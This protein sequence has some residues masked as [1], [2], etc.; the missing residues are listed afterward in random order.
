M[1]TSIEPWARRFERQHPKRPTHHL[2]VG[3]NFPD[4]RHGRVEERD[5]LGVA[6]ETLV[7]SCLG[8]QHP[9]WLSEYAVAAVNAIARSGRPLALLNLGA[10]APGLSGLDSAVAVHKPGYLRAERFAT[11]LAASDL[12]L[13]PLVDGVSTRRGSLMAALQHGL[14]VVGT[15]G[16]LTDS[17]LREAGPAL[18]LTEV[19]DVDSFSR[20]AAQLAN[21]PAAR[22]RAGAAA[23]ALYEREFEWSVI[24]DKLLAALP[25]S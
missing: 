10:E 7:I 11:M 17:V 21:D 23:R 15:V 25:D 4:A 3:S 5:R 20:S 14:P 6:E 13:T 9:G 1:L 2:P 24:A 18:H 19:G 16:P 22:A 8:R 12:F